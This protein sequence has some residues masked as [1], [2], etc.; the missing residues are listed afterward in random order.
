MTLYTLDN[1][2]IEPV[3][4][5]V[6]RIS[7]I[8]IIII[9]T[10]VTIFTALFGAIY[11]LFSHEVYSYYMIYAFAIPL[12]MGLTPFLICRFIMKKELPI[13]SSYC[14]NCSI[15]TLTIGSMFKGVLDI[16][17]TTNRLIYV[18]PAASII[19]MIIGLVSL[20]KNKVQAEKQK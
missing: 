15:A 16:Y 19:L 12:I 7:D 1:T 13:V 18:Y 17:G 3:N 4:S 8:K 10:F 20:I 14:W 6:I 2:A 11:E 5:E 9:Y